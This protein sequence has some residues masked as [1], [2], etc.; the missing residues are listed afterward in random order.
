MNKDVRTFNERLLE[1]GARQ[2]WYR[3]VSI[4][5]DI[6]GMEIP[7]T[8]CAMRVHVSPGSNSCHSLGIELVLTQI[9][10]FYLILFFLVALLHEAEQRNA[11]PLRSGGGVELEMR[12]SF[13]HGVEEWLRRCMLEIVWDLFQ[14]RALTYFS[15]DL[16]AAGPSAAFMLCD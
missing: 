6:I 10:V 3:P 7:G 11:S 2:G 12:L 14:N 8:N 9:N 4:D 13:V 1:R 15:N 16:V 5:L